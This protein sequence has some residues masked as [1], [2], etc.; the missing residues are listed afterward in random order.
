[1]TE[2]VCPAGRLRSGARLRPKC[3]IVWPCSNKH[4]FLNRAVYPVGNDCLDNQDRNG[5]GLY[6]VPA[7]Q[8][9]DSVEH[10]ELSDGFGQT[11]GYFGKLKSEDQNDHK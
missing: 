8:P 3:R 4:P 2:E 5:T 10:P 1:M 6:P 7:P 9:Q 11:P